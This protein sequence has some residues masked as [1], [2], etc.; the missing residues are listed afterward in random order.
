MAVLALVVERLITPAVNGITGE[1]TPDACTPTRPPAS[2]PSPATDYSVPR[3]P[4]FSSS[5]SLAEPMN[6]GDVVD[7]HDPRRVLV[8]PRTTREE[9]V[10]ASCAAS[11]TPAVPVVLV[12]GGRL[13]SRIA[14]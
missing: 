9:L 11:L 14:G 10:A 8:P 5:Q 13:P 1:V 12:G 4:N 6:A 3:E 2:R 7:Q